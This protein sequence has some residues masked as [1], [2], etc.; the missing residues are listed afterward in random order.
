MGDLRHFKKPIFGVVVI[1]M[2]GILVGRYLPFSLYPSLIFYFILI[3]TLGFAILGYL[4][5]KDKMVIFF[6]FT[7]IFLAGILH[8]LI[9]YFPSRKDIVKYAP[10]RKPVVIVGRII[11]SPRLREGKKKRVSFI[12]KPLWLEIESGENGGNFRP[13]LTKQNRKKV[14]GKVWVTSFFPYRYYKYGDIVRIKGKLSIP[15]G[16]QGKNRFNW[17]RYLSYQGIWTEITTGRVEILERNKGNPILHLIFSTGKWMEDEI[18]KLLPYPY[19]SILK[20]IML[21][22]KED[23]PSR[24]LDNFRTT[25]TAHVLVVSGLH[26]GLL[27]FIL[28]TLFR[29]LRFPRKISFCLSLPVIFYYALMTGLRPPI[30]RAS[31]M[32]TVGII[33]YLLDR[34]VPLPVILFL[35][36]FVVLILDPLS[37]FSVSFQLSFLAV[38]GIIFF[39]PYFQEKFKFLPGWLRTSLSVSIAAQLCLLP[40]LGF[41]FGQFP[42]IGILANLIIVPLITFILALGFLSLAL[43]IFTFQGAQILANTNWLGLHALLSIVNFFSFSRFPYLNL[44]FSP[45]VN[46]FP[47][48]VILVYYFIVVIFTHGEYLLKKRRL[49]LPEDEN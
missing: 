23:L 16:A 36:A 2:A 24:V 14:D 11:N 3:G 12:I 22:D 5:S 34:E 4:K 37:L 31:L 28:V 35:A 46:P 41:Y 6:I 47:A 19:S 44:F 25:G 29:F 33:C 32:A 1:F 7:G 42:L 39:T 13:C 15:R 9:C 27:L 45:K 49:P 18:D 38:G 40:L 10:S 17:Q 20:G 48:W 43:S 26:V 21:G 30:I 8:F